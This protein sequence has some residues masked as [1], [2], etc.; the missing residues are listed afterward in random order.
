MVNVLAFAAGCV[1]GWTAIRLIFKWGI[2]RQD[3]RRDF[4]DKLG[5]AELVDFR[6]A[7]DAEINKRKG[8]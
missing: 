5:F 1:V 6:D 3:V 8:V 7:A 4:L 2:R